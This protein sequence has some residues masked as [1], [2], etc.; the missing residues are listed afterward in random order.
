MG[1]NLSIAIKAAI[2]AGI[3]ILEIYND[4]FDVELKSDE[5]PITKADLKANDIIN[6]YLESTNIPIISEENKL[7]P[8]EKREDWKTCWIVDPLDGTKEFIQKNDEFTV[9]IALVLDGNPILGV[10]YLPVQKT[11]YYT[12]EGASKAFK[13]ILSGKNASMDTISENALEIIPYS[14]NSQLSSVIKILVSRSHLNTE[15]KSYISEMKKD[16]LVDIVS[17]GSSLKFCLLAEG[18]ANLYPRFSPTME[19]DTAA[20]QAI[21]TAV[22]L[23]V[24]DPASRKL[25]NYNK[26]NLLN[27]SFLAGDR[28][29]LD[30]N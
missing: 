14:S 7:L 4:E 20:G 27:G 3:A 25:L 5:S 23:E 2:E 21:C 9:N 19:W 10:I 18:K 28:A 24:I 22:G 6:R 17:V 8:Y 29:L 26:K 1:D 16:N 30:S 12:D 11:L 15:T 13:I